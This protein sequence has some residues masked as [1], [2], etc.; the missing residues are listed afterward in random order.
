VSAQSEPKVLPLNPVELKKFPMRAG[1]DLA[2]TKIP[3]T[4]WTAKVGS[5]LCV[6]VDLNGDGVLA[7]EMDGVGITTAPFI[8][9]IPAV[10][11]AS[12]GQFDVSFEGVKSLVLKGQALGKLT[13]LVQ[14]VSIVTELRIRA[15][16]R[17]LVL[18]AGPSAACEKHCDY[19][20]ANAMA[21]GSGGMKAHEELEHKPGYTTDGWTAGRKSCIGFAYQSLKPAIL[22]WYATAWHGA[23]MLDPSVTKFGV[24]LKNGV[25]MF[26]P[27]DAGGA[28]ARPALHPADGATEVPTTFG[29]RGEI[30]NPVP[31]TPNGVG[32]GFPIMMRLVNKSVVLKAAT[33]KDSKG[34]AITG[35]LSCPTRPANPEWPENSG[36]ALFIPSV[37][38]APK[39]K[40]SVRFELEGAP[41]V[42]WSFTTR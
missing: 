39:T 26:Y 2:G 4:G 21:D 10:I 30:P 35:N 31:G 8:V 38:L 28:P 16:L 32:C 25:A 37:P 12:H 13:P 15:G 29:A 3:A 36:L 14:D 40:Y 42:D 41:S 20:K 22:D 34:S 11:L 19:L 27:S 5:V 7:P 23:P 33:V 1:F 9:P 18:E 17:P 6:F 24:A